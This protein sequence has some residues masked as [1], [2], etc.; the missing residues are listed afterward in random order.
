MEKA[1]RFVGFESCLWLPWQGQ[2][3]YLA[4][5]SDVPHLWRDQRKVYMFAVF[6]S[7]AFV[8]LSKLKQLLWKIFH[9]ILVIKGNK[10][11]LSIQ[12]LLCAEI[13]SQT[14]TIGHRGLNFL[15]EITRNN[16]KHF[17]TWGAFIKLPAQ[18]QKFL[19]SL[20]SQIHNIFPIHPTFILVDIVY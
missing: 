20:F 9:N 3:T 12:D 19:T 7:E 16:R 2:R 11:S 1:P 8:L 4:H 5:R 18:E 10:K 6:S 15:L 13:A 17:M 14:H